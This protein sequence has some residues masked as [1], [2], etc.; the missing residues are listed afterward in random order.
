MGKERFG[1][2]HRVEEVEVLAVLI[3]LEIQRVKQLNE[4]LVKLGEFDVGGTS[5]DLPLNNGNFAILLS[6]QLLLLVKLSTLVFVLSVDLH[7][8]RVRVVLLNLLFPYFG[9]L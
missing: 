9:L 8:C 1:I 6:Q 3:R 2:L 5:F 7:Q 4:S